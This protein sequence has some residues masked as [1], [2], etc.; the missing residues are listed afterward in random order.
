MTTD[1]VTEARDPSGALYGAARL[2]GLLQRTVAVG[3][4]AAA[5]VGAVVDDVRGFADGAEAADDLTILVL[6]WKGPQ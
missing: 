6:R 1:G 3:P 5:L 2:Q 4:D